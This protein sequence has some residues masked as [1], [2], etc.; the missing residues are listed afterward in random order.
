MSRGGSRYGA[1]RPAH[2]IKAESVQRVE[3]RRW[4]RA[5]YFDGNHYFSAGWNRG[6]EPTGSISVQTTRDSAVL[7]Y[8]IKDFQSDE[9]QDKRQHIPVELTPCNYGGN[10]RWFRCP[11]CQRRCESLFLRS[12]RFACRLCQK[13]AYSSQAGGPIDRMTHKLHKMRARL[14][15]GKPCGMRWSTFNKLRDR[16]ETIEVIVDQM[17]GNRWASLFPHAFPDAASET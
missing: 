4:V 10:R 9:W 3:I 11:V 13:V 8:R 12:H 15:H 14:D 7:S 5:G 17:I 2:N 6:G 1:G 16:A